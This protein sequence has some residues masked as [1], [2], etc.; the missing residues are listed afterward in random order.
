MFACC[1]TLLQQAKADCKGVTSLEYA[2]IGVIMVIMVAAA[3]PNM[4]AALAGLFGS[5][6]AGY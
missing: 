1:L 6:V 4:A 3:L 2:I 5:V